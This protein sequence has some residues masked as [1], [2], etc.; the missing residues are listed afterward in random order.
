MRPALLGAPLTRRAGGRGLK[1]VKASVILGCP[2][3]RKRKGIG[4][5]FD[6]RFDQI[7]HD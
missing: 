4:R 2:A 1:V 3:C 7:F 5:L 6:K